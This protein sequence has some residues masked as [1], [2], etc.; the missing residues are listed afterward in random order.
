[1]RTR[2]YQKVRPKLSIAFLRHDTRF[3]A[4]FW[5]EAKIFSI[6]DRP[7]LLLRREHLEIIGLKSFCPGTQNATS[8]CLAIHFLFL[9]RAFVTPQYF[10][11]ERKNQCLNQISETISSFYRRSGPLLVLMQV[12]SRT[13]REQSLPLLR[14]ARGIVPGKEG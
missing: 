11:K 14:I 4:Q 5:P 7:F 12:S 3:N 13:R 6:F 1:M 2:F 10:G 9:P 8:I